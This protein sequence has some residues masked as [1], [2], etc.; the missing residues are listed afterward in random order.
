M[1][2]IDS[3]YSKDDKGRTGAERAGKRNSFNKKDVV[4]NALVTLN[5]VEYRSRQ[6]EEEANC[7][8][9]F[10]LLKFN[11]D[12]ILEGN[13]HDLL[14]DVEYTLFVDFDTKTKKKSAQ[15]REFAN[16][17]AMLSGLVGESESR[18]MQTAE[19]KEIVR[20]FLLTGGESC[21]GKQFH[22]QSIPTGNGWHNFGFEAAPAVSKAKK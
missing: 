16:F 7:G 3:F 11:I 14:K 15:I 5:A 19:G 1:D 10:A 12:Q 2:F 22:M 21:V 18:L 13:T 20:D 9:K 4:V 8:E 17:V 6:N